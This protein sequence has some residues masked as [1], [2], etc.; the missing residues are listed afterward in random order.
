SIMKTSQRWQPAGVQL[1]FDGT[2]LSDEQGVFLLGHHCDFF[3]TAGHPYERNFEREV[4]LIL[5]L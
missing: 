2:S 1:R 5:R 4:I 3:A